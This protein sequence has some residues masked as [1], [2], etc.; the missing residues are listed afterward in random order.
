MFTTYTSYYTIYISASSELP[1]A[2]MPSARIEINND[3]LRVDPTIPAIMRGRVAES[4]WKQ[5]CD[6]V[7]EHLQEIS[8]ARQR[9]C[10]HFF[11]VFAWVLCLVGYGLSMVIDFGFPGAPIIMF[12]ITFFGTIIAVFFLQHTKS[13]EKSSCEKIR[14]VCEE[15]SKKQSLVSYHFREDE[16]VTR[17]S[18]G[19]SETTWKY[20]IDVSISDTE[21]M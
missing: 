6:K 2:N 21:I 17:D 5:F 11:I 10:I 4:D 16:I 15:E 20:S 1:T 14:R 9:A 8:N 19:D 18:D 7:D 3:S 12:S 13:K